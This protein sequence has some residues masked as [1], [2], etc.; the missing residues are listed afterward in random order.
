[1]NDQRDRHDQPDQREEP[2]IDPRVSTHYA[3][4]ADEAAPPELDR[5]V[6]QNASSAVR[7]EGRK[8]PFMAWLRPAAFVA[9]AGL[10]FALVLDLN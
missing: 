8:F 2:A 5:I 7:T 9:T 6:L 1:M 10:S 4:L 3:L